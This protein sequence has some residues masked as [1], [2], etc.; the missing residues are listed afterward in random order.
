MASQQGFTHLQ[1][2]KR[3]VNESTRHCF[4][5]ATLDWLKIPFPLSWR[6]GVQCL[7][8]N[9]S[10]GPW[11][12]LA[13]ALPSQEGRLRWAT[14]SAVQIANAKTKWPREAW[15]SDSHLPPHLLRTLPN[16][17]FTQLK[18]CNPFQERSQSRCFIIIMTTYRAVSF[19]SASPSSLL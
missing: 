5:C 18:E 4:L 3:I 6:A 11:S 13:T 10:P 7:P 16:F 19:H 8:L 12:G 14:E 1:V 15:T 2:S 17:L 9:R